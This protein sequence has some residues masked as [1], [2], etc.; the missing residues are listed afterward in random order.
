MSVRRVLIAHQSTIP[1]YRVAFYNAVERLR[2]PWWMFAVTYDPDPARRAK[3]FAEPIDEQE[4]GFPVLC[5]RTIGAS[6]F[7]KQLSL[8]RRSCS[9]SRTTIW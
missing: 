9:A 5:T 6:V 8:I 1:H 2:P 4:F 7:G 3:L